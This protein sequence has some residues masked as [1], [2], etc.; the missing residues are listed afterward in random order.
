MA[1]RSTRVRAPQRP[2][3]TIKLSSRARLPAVITVQ[4]DYDRD[5]WRPLNQRLATPYS[6]VRRDCGA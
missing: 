2:S 5:I 3:C 6:K 4:E 1:R